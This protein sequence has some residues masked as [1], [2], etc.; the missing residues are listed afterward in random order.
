MIPNGLSGAAG[1]VAL[2]ALML[3]LGVFF[4]GL[5]AVTVSAALD[6]HSRNRNAVAETVGPDP[7]DPAETALP[8]DPS[9]D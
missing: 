8:D 6:R 5:L 2:L 1:L 7:H 4:V 9:E 3:S